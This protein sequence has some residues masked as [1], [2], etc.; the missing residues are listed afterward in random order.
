MANEWQKLTTMTGGEEI[1]VKRVSTRNSN[2]TIEGDFSLPPLAQLSYDDQVFVGMF[3]K[4]HGSIK[5]MEQAF[6]ISYPTVKSRLNK[7]S[8]SLGFVETRDVP[9]REEILGQ[10]ERGE[11]SVDEAVRRLS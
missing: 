9:Q 6:G 8:Q 4:V 7:I 11:I 2:I 10:V 1:T 5:E 3:I